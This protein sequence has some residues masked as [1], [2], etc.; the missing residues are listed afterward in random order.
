MNGIISVPT[1]RST[2]SSKQIV[3]A[4]VAGV[5][6]FSGFIAGINVTPTHF[7]KLAQLN[8]FHSET[9][10]Y[11]KMTWL[12]K[13]AETKEIHFSEA[14]LKE[15]VLA[16]NVDF[17]PFVLDTKPA[18]KTYVQRKKGSK[19]RTEMF[20]D[21]KMAYQRFE[22]VMKEKTEPK[23]EHLLFDFEM[24]A[25]KIRQ[26][27]ITTVDPSVKPEVLIASYDPQLD[28]AP[29]VTAPIS[30]SL[31]LVS[32][33]AE[34]PAAMKTWKPAP[35]KPE[36]K[37]DRQARAVIAVQTP[38]PEPLPM[39][40][41]VVYPD[42]TLDNQT[43]SIQDETPSAEI[44]QSYSAVKTDVKDDAELEKQKWAESLLA[45][46]FENQTKGQVASAQRAQAKAATRQEAAR[47]ENTADPNQTAKED[48]IREDSNVEH[49]SFAGARTGCAVLPNHSFVK[50]N[51]SPVEGE[52]NQ[53]CP[54]R[55]E[56]LSKNWNDSGW[57][58]VES[59]DYI[60]TLTLHPAANG[61]STL[62]LDQ[63]ALALIALRS[64]VRV[65]QG[66]GLIVGVVPTG[67]KVEFTGRGEETE[68]F[69]IEQKKYFA[70]LNAEPGA[71][72]IQLLSEQNQK[73]NSTVFAPVLEGTVTYLDLAAP[74]ARNIGVQVLKNSEKVDAEVAG[75]T[76]GISTQGNIQAITNSE[77]KTILRAVHIVPGYPVFIDVSS[78]AKDQSS[79][80]YRYSLKHQNK[81]GFYIVN[82]IADRTLHRWLKQVKM[83]LSDQSAM[84]VGF[85][86]RKI[87]DGF[88]KSYFTKVEPK[89]AHFGLEPLNYTVMWDGKISQ[90]E[91]LEG[92]SPRFMSVQVPEG[93]SQIHL[94]NE[95]KKSVNTQLM[96]ISPR[97]IHVVSE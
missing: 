48:L 4:I 77:G 25:K 38:T 19:K 16:V 78:K 79:Y 97:V 45:L 63:N 60:P 49:N 33:S 93:L 15:T 26:D 36:S 75:L 34:V 61:G 18:K 42:S 53:I 65:A 14:P 2:L 91:P 52:S 76:V 82:Q 67:Y 84:V 22:T 96:P 37:A 21:L 40:T 54:E 17:I 27:F 66:M 51:P 62:V 72:V 46:R 10:N 11:S 71:G 12:Q 88:K 55:N 31:T 73:L 3:T 24:A 70:V 44:E 43:V 39:V 23:D 83:G 94:L 13:E 92:D 41:D 86:N 74:Q 30:E 29:P 87:L 1:S 81:S 20:R 32:S 95:A 57:T 85:Y 35:K 68:Y 58:K 80:T 59:A 47:D 28:V 64:G 69:E 9:I 90:E 6:L 89:S 56:W 5:C 7:K 8:P 50:P